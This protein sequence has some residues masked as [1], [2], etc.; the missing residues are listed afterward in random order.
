MAKFDEQEMLSDLF[1]RNLF[2]G[3]DWEAPFYRSLVEADSV[4]AALLM[5]GERSTLIAGQIALARPL[6]VLAIDKFDGA[7][8][9]IRTELATGARNYPSSTTHSPQ[10]LV[11]WLKE[12]RKEWAEQLAQARQREND[13]LKITSQRRKTL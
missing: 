11:A 12:R 5:A 1:E 3:N 13:Y 7:A 10:A 4:D 8:V 6:P 9:V 2:A